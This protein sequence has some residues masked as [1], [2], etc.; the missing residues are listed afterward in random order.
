MQVSRQE[1]SEYGIASG[2]APPE[3]LSWS[4][5]RLPM[6][7]RPLS[8]SQ[9]RGR[10]RTHGSSEEE[11]HLMQKLSEVAAGAQPGRKRP[12]CGRATELAAQ[13]STCGTTRSVASCI[14][15]E[16]MPSLSISPADAATYS[17]HTPR[18][19]EA[20]ATQARPH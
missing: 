5:A 13:R 1:P 10:G 14:D 4:V 8:L 19:L 9:P 16:S 7:F 3:A 6:S 12:R 11:R 20:P 18:T 2:G 17:A 15:E